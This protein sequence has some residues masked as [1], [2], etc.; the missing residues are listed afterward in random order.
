MYS[1]RSLKDVSP[2]E[3]IRLVN[4]VFKDYI[5]PIDWNLKSFEK[6]VKEYSISLN[7]SFVCYD[8]GNP[9]GFSIVSHRG[10]LGRIDS[11]GVLPQYRGEGIASEII[12]RTIENLK[13]KG[14]KKI[15]LEVEQNEKRAINF[16]KK[17]GF[18]AKRKLISLNLKTASKEKYNY[19]YVEEDNIWLKENAF[20]AK[21][22]LGR[23]PNWQ[24]HPQTL[25]K[26][27]DRYRIEKVVE[28][29][30]TIGYVAWGENVDNV[31]IVDAS[32]IDD[33]TPFKEFISDVVKR[34]TEK[35]D[36]VSVVAV[37]EDDLLYKALLDNGFKEF[38]IQVEMKEKIH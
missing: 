11:I 34:V 21:T 17:H 26:S 10:E 9:I 12:Y 30:Y 18:K 24:R 22:N 25:E 27:E 33:K 20:K 31:Y 32:P 8:D 16:Y 23:K 28:W 13:W 7:D 3:V 5:V 4:N 37:P 6:D 19:K 35:H 14:V 29:G 36:S 1:Y 15:I 38:L 2:V